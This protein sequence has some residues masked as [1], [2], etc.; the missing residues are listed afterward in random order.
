MEDKK[1]TALAAKAIAGDKGAF[2]ELYAEHARSI[3][4]HVRS[5]IVD[6]DNYTDV[7][8]DVALEMLSDIHKLREPAAFRGWMHQVVRTTCADHNRS[9]MSAEKHLSTGDNE[10]QLEAV[11][12]ETR[13]AD[14]EAV[15]LATME[16]NQLFAI[17]SELPVIH[18]EVIVQRYYDDLSYK[19]IAEAQGISVTNVS[20]RLQ[21]AMEAIR[22]RLGEL[23][24][25][26]P[27]QSISASV[28]DKGTTMKEDNINTQQHL[29]QEAATGG[30]SSEEPTQEELT[31]QGLNDDIGLKSSLLSGVPLLIPDDTVSTV[32]NSVSVKLVGAEQAATGT[33]AGSSTGASAAARMLPTALIAIISSLAVVAAIVAGVMVFTAQSSDTAAPQT[34]EESDDSYTVD[35]QSSMHIIFTDANGGNT[36][37]NVVGI[38]LVEDEPI[39]AETRWELLYLG[40]RGAEGGLGVDAGAGAEASTGGDATVGNDGGASADAGAGTSVGDELGSSIL[41]S[42]SGM[43]IGSETLAG[44]QAGNYRIVFTLTNEDGALAEI[45]RSFSV[46]Q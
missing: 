2:E 17:V 42:G 24:E 31:Q 40:E 13:E 3:L 36:D 9:L 19:E 7:A 6:K 29:N 18:R 4:F 5:L 21:R 44:L 32:V 41:A 22:K 23:G 28:P 45:S 14:P 15:A 37:L 10:E 33:G 12:D 46:Y 25:G 26:A 20:T 11:E 34:A 30:A 38:D 8:Q 35:Y 27:V 39:A 16:G 43:R 1:L